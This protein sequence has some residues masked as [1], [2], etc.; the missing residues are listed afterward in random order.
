M[1][2]HRLVFCVILL[3]SACKANSNIY[4]YKCGDVFMKFET[5]SEYNT[6]KS[7]EEET[8]V[9]VRVMSYSQLKHETGSVIFLNDKNAAILNINNRTYPRCTRV[10]PSPQINIPNIS[11]W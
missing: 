3:I 2:K 9:A 6:A 4:T 5:M 8:L 11:L 1:N 7:G 10:K